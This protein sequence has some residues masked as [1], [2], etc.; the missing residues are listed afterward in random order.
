MVGAMKMK[1]FLMIMLPVGQAFARVD[2][3]K[4]GPIPAP[5]PQIS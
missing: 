5:P 3:F 4:G 1:L 2:L